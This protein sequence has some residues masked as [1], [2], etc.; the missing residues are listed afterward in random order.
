M[1]LLMNRGSTSATALLGVLLLVPPPAL[2]QTVSATTAEDCVNIYRAGLDQCGAEWGDRD[3]DSYSA[4][5]DAYNTASYDYDTKIQQNAADYAASLQD[6]C[7]A[8]LYL[9]TGGDP[10]NPGN[11]GTCATKLNADLAAALVVYNQEE[12][13]CNASYPPPDDAGYTSCMC[14]PVAQYAFK[15]ADVTDLSEK[16]KSDAQSTY[17]NCSD[18]YKAGQTS[19]DTGELVRFNYKVQTANAELQ[20]QCTT[21]CVL[22]GIH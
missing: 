3:F 8:N 6:P 18:G 13:R 21:Q 16:C 2:I 22:G 4:Y 19:K 15:R 1:R 17:N 10:L 7:Q 14:K 20:K 5:L 11:P 9:A 12:A